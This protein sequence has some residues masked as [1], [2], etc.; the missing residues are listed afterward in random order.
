M[1]K[2]ITDNGNLIA[3]IAT[4][5]CC[6]I[7]I[8]LMVQTIPLA[9]E[10]QGV[11]AGLIGLNTSLGQL[12]V[13]LCGLALPR[14]TR[15]FSSKSIVLLAIGILCL[16]F[17][18]FSVTEPMWA[19]YGIRFA[20][21]LGIAALFTLSE[22]WITLAAGHGRRARI[23][24]IYTSVL[25]VTFGVGPFVVAATGFSGPLPWL[26]GAACMVPGFLAVMLVRVDAPDAGDVGGSFFA[27]LRK[28]PAIYACILATTTFEA[29]CLSFFTIYGMRNG[30]SYAT[31]NQILGVGIVGCLLLFYP[32]GQL[33][34]RW[35]RGGTATLCACVAVAFSL[36]T[37]LTI[38]HPAI[39]PVT[40]ILRAGAFGV[41]IVAISAVGDTFKGTE[42]VGA[43]ALVAIGWGV[44]GM[45]GPPLA[46]HLID[47][48]GIHLLPWMMAACYGLALIAL[49]LNQWRMVP[50]AS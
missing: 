7:A 38:T 33:A 28:A 41:Y 27:V 24:G 4:L 49:G 22:T 1:S 11:S 13:F 12:G 17:L 14:L 42:L 3:A 20:G 15:R 19:W 26:I 10:A 5:A 29:V 36:L 45:A 25:T 47:T 9:M 2:F 34:D 50:K 6:N 16:S 46:G 43:S 18:M 21:G 48:F 32:I 44:G 39:W 8:G 35:S 30:L 37:M 40:I 31:A 23:M